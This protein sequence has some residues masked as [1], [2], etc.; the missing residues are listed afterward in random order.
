MRVA[1]GGERSLGVGGVDGRGKGETNVYILRICLKF[2]NR[3]S[4]A[5]GGE[6]WLVKAVSQ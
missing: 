1:T 5:R 2:E 4:M 3:E 6:G